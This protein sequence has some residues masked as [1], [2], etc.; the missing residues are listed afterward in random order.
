MF[1]QRRSPQR[2]ARTSSGALECVH[3]GA[4]FLEL[5]PATALL[6]G[7]QSPRLAVEHMTS[8]MALC[9][10]ALLASTFAVF[11]PFGH[12]TVSLCGMQNPRLVT[13]RRVTTSRREIAR[14]DRSHLCSGIRR[15]CSHCAR[16]CSRSHQPVGGCGELLPQCYQR[17]SR[18]T[19]SNI[20]VQPRR[21][22]EAVCLDA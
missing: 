8:Q 21:G 20:P 16:S 18:T 17:P 7:S 13:G 2:L 6:R 19:C 9:V 11:V 3:I 15:R 10:L 4:S 22:P 1:G 14:E 12:D 5:A